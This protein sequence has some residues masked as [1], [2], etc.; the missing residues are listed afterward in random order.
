MTR[1]MIIS[2]KHNDLMDGQYGECLEEI[3]G[4]EEEARELAREYVPMHSPVGIVEVI[5]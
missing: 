3:S 1:W 5:R 4:T 2:W